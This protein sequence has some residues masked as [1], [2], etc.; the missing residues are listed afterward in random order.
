MMPNL[1]EIRDLKIGARTD[2]GRE[3]QIIK[4]VSIDVAAGEIVALIGESGSGKTTIALSLM[5]HVRPGCYF[6]GGSVTVAGRDMAALRES[7]RAKLRGTDVAY[8]PQSAAA[9]FNPA[10]KLIDQVVEVAKI[11][12]L[13]PMAEAR[14]IA[15]VL[16]TIRDPDGFIGA[17]TLAREKGVPVVVLKLGRSA[18]AKQFA[19]SHSGA[20]S[21]SNAGYDA[22][23]ARHGVIQ[24][25]SLDE[26]LDTAELMALRR[27]MP[28][29]G[30]ALGTDSGGERQ[31]ISDLAA[32]QGLPFADLTPQ[33]L[34]A[35]EA[36]LD[37]GMEASNPLDYWGDGG[38]VM[39]PVLTEMAGDPGVGILVMA[40]NLP[41][42]RPFSEQ[43]ATAIRA[44]HAATDKPVVVMGNIASTIS[45]AIAAELRG[46]GIAVLMGTA[47]G[48]AA[49]G[50]LRAWRFAAP[51]PDDTAALPLSV[52]AV[53]RIAG[54]PLDMLRSFD[55][56]G[57]LAG[58]GIPCAA[59]AEIT[60]PAQIGAFAAEH[61][62][63]LV[64][65]IDDA[66]IAH[67]SDQGGVFIGLRD[68]EEA[69]VAWNALRQRHPAA[70]VIVQA[71]ETGTEIILGMTTDP[72]FGPLITLGLGGVFAEILRDTTTLLP[73]YSPAT[74]RR[75]LESLQAFPLLT[76]ARA[77]PPAD[78]DALCALISR[79]SAF[80][81]GAADHL[82]EIEINPVLAGPKGAV[83]VDCIALRQ[84]PKQK[85]AARHGQ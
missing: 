34:A 48:L 20:L 80:A 23:F 83:A 55:G 52:A 47:S 72:D 85:E 37:P 39:A 74:A 14:V 7:E 68:E 32:D 64:L 13:M 15:C 16:E 41:P 76:G 22:V 78:L 8:V 45:P 84:T 57:L 71:M 19:I 31:L 77:R 36:H 66:A 30:I 33:T 53:E 11:H 63:P 62:W 12:N 27:V 67:K 56:F 24:V 28:A 51:V 58:A 1:V 21:G 38:D 4:G 49:L 82:R 59:V 26:L 9:A 60:A 18:A 29:A 17:V 3:V 10:I 2:S 65:K 25:R 61:G 73:P 81:A 70:P 5:G 6:Q 69:L 44:V 35:V 43:S 75:A 54:A 42:D 46:R 79:F 40:T 50:H